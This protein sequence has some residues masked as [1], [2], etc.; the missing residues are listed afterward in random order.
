LNGF[1]KSVLQLALIVK[2]TEIN[3]CQICYMSNPLDFINS[4]LKVTDYKDRFW[5]GQLKLNYQDYI[6]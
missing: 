1:R 6:L 2:I 3:T 4:D 5:G